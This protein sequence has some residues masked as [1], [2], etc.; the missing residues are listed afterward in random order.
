MSTKKLEILET[1]AVGG[2][3]GRSLVGK[4]VSD[5]SG[6]VLTVIGAS[7]GTTFGAHEAVRQFWEGLDPSRFRGEVRVVLLP[8]VDA[9]LTNATGPNA[10][11]LKSLRWPGDPDGPVGD[12]IAAHLTR[13]VVQGSDALI[14]VSGGEYVHLLDL[15]V[16]VPRGAA[17]P[18][19][20][21]NEAFAEALGFPYY[22]RPHIDSAHAGKGST[23]GEALRGGSLAATIEIGGSG[24]YTNR[25]VQ[26]VLT[27]LDNAMVYLNMVDGERRLVDGEPRRI[28]EGVL[29]RSE[30]EGILR[31]LVQ[32]AELVKAGTLLSTVT[33]LFGTV[34]QE[35]RAP[36]DLYVMCLAT[37]RGVTPGA[38]AIKVGLL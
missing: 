29:L 24:Q 35:I 6:E 21:A 8:D 30:H 38:F 27:G 4:A 31:H 20:T 5:E 36:Q 34:V 11:I 10:L 13:E 1:V 18:L 23:A 3:V 26:A 33:D 22:D 32:P 14:A 19:D 2:T 12:A 37:A 16:L 17:E 25:Q 28:R 15:Y 7:C 9:A